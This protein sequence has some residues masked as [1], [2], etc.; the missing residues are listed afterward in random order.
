M[1]RETDS[2]VRLQ[3]V[4]QLPAVLMSKEN[5]YKKTKGE[6][7]ILNWKE[8]ESS[9][10]KPWRHFNH[11]H[12]L[13]SKMDGRVSGDWCQNRESFR[14]QGSREIGMW[15]DERGREKQ[16]LKEKK[17]EVQEYVEFELHNIQWVTLY[18]YQSLLKLIMWTEVYTRDNWVYTWSSG[19]MHRLFS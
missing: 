5:Q 4:Y 6:H 15:E 18:V 12:D 10:S 11:L 1:H 7:M 2:R 19:P 3:R 8:V 13:Y 17:R 14:V 16:A 9:L